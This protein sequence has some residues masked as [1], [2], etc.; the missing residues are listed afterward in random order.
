MC[1]W[2]T[3]CVF[4]T[5][6]AA[7]V[8]VISVY[9]NHPSSSVLPQLALISNRTLVFPDAPC[10]TKWAH[11]NTDTKGCNDTSKVRVDKA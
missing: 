9:T 7:Y 6:T 5:K 4:R 2:Y 1:L 3:S 8:G 10:H 11:R